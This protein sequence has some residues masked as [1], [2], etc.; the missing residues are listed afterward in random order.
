MKIRDASIQVQATAM[1][2]VVEATRHKVDI[3]E[4]QNVFM[5]FT[6][7]KTWTISENIREYF[8]A[9]VALSSRSYVKSLSK[10]CALKGDKLCKQ[11]PGKDN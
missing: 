4:D 2:E 3:L 1:K 10:Y 6:T 8:T 11:R 5:L 7:P 9:T